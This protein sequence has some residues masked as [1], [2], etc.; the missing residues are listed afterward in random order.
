MSLTNTYGKPPYNIVLIHGGPGAIG[1]MKPVAETLSSGFGI[2]EPLQ[3]KYSIKEL[4]DELKESIEENSDI[5]VTLVGYSWG[6][7]LAIIFASTY[8][9]LVKKVIL[10]S[11]APFENK[12]IPIMDQTRKE[13][14]TEADRETLEQLS[15]E[16]INTDINKK[17]IMEK[18]GK[19]YSKL[20]SYSPISHDHSSIQLDLDMY[21]KI[22]HEASK[23]RESGKL[24]EYLKNI[25]CPIIAIHGDYDGHPAEG[26][27]EPLE[28]HSKDSKFIL[29]KNCG[30]TPWYEEKAK[31]KF[32]TVLQK[33]ISD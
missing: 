1:E 16:L 7:W 17:D 2:L 10:I 28:K 32:Y 4:I 33:I 19:L 15:R 31:E 20:D 24:L 5:P 14:M 30:H 27:E 25:T 29:L 18:M 21:N 22:W 12:Y 11:S 13:R 9:K 3:A 8:P 23:M 26:V 6:A